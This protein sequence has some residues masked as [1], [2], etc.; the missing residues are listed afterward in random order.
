MRSA[1]AYPKFIFGF[2]IF[3]TL[4][5][6]LVLIPR[7]KDIFADFNAKLPLLTRAYLG[8]SDFLTSNALF[9]APTAIGLY[10]LYRYLRR[11]PQLAETFDRITLGVPFFGALTL[12]AAIDR[13]AVTAGALLSNGIPLTDALGIASATLNNTLLEKEIR[14]V[15]S[16]VMKGYGLAESLARAP[17]MPRL[18]ARM[19]HVGEE[20][21]TLG[22]MFEEVAGYYDQEVDRALGR[23]AAII[24]PILICGMGVIVLTTLLALYLPIFGLSRTVGG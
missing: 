17:H 14:D 22:A 4:V 9:I 15:R 5:I 3:I 18:V 16:D 20:S 23:V 19:A 1:T 24:E 2:F 21:G 11:M 13:M 12:K 7:F 6:F 10:A 8:V